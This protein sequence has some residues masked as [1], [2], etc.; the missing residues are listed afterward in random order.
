MRLGALVY[1]YVFNFRYASVWV[2]I[3]EDV[4]YHD[5]RVYADIEQDIVIEYRYTEELKQRVHALRRHLQDAL[6][7][8]R[9]MVL[10]H[11]NKID[12]PHVSG[13][14]RFGDDPQTSVLDRN[15]CVHGMRNLFV[16]D[17]SFF[18][19]SAG[20]NPSLTIAANALRVARGIDRAIFAGGSS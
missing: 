8:R 5:N 11:N 16:V 20:T 9:L 19:S 6:G 10:S 15:N 13:T 18:P 1:F 12:Y 4:P 14:C 7:S 17:A 2:S 3:V